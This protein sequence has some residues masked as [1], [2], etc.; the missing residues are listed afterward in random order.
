MLN[1]HI[2]VYVK[3]R[4]TFIPFQNYNT[5]V[6]GIGDQKSLY[7]PERGTIEVMCVCVCVCVFF[8]CLFVFVFVVEKLYNIFSL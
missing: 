1:S 5:V 8:V 4:Q 3:L 6:H 7:Y 2:T